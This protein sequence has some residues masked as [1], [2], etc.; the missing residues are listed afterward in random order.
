GGSGDD[1]LHI[2]APTPDGGY[3]LGGYSY[4]SASGDKSENSKG[5]SDY[6]V[7]KIDGSGNKVWDKTF[8]GSGE[9]ILYSTT[10]T[11]DG[12]YLLGGYSA[13]PASGNKS[14]NSKGSYDY[15]IVKI[16]GSGNKVWDKTFGGSDN[17]I[18]HS[19]TPS[20]DGGFLLAGSS[21]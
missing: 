12:G 17:D 10:P 5:G 8:G 13:S 1:F 4:S 6:W 18:L 7:V 11:P 2:T 20:P 14:E 9:D 21:F 3:L 19:T 15:W 16:D